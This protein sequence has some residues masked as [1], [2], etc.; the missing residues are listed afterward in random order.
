MLVV[1][2]LYG[3]T[4]M[5]EHA[6]HLAAAQKTEELAV[7]RQKIRDHHVSAAEE[8]LIGEKVLSGFFFLVLTCLI[9]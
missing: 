2:A 5:L 4:N 1:S 7:V 3:V 6:C 9:A 8:L